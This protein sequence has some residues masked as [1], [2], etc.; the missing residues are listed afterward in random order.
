[1][2]DHRQSLFGARY[3]ATSLP[4]TERL[5]DEVLTLPCHPAMTDEE[6][7]HVIA[8]CAGFAA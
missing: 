8:A 7:A 3:A 1:V 6:V 5:A 2:P 4:V